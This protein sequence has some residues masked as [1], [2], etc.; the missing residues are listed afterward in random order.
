MRL[1]EVSTGT[2]PLGGAGI[3]RIAWGKADALPFPLCVS[4]TVTDENGVAT[5]VT[6]G[7]ASGNIVLVDHGLTVVGRPSRGGAAVEARALPP[8]GRPVRHRRRGPDRAAVR[9]DPP[10]LAR[11]AHDPLRR[12]GGGSRCPSLG[13]AGGVARGSRCVTASGAPWEARADLLGSTPTAPD[14]VVE[15]EADDEAHLRFGDG[16]H[17]ARPT[18]GTTF[19]A[20]YRIG[21]GT[22]G[23]VGAEAI[24]HVAERPRPGSSA[25]ATRCRRPGAS[26]P[27]RVEEVRRF[28]PVAFRTQERAVTADDYA[29]M[30]ERH[31]RVQRAAGSF[32]WTGSWRTAFVTVDPL[33]GDDDTVEEDLGTAVTRRL[34]RYRHGRRRRSRGHA[35]LRAAQD[36]DDGLR[37]AR[38]LPLRR[39]AGAPRTVQQH[40]PARRA[41]RAVPSRRVHVRPAGLPR[42]GCTRPRPRSTASRRSR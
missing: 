17:G 34:E 18:A 24:A 7:V 26:I 23:N 14:F 41:A 27:S 38:V 22:G 39:Q 2:D 19:S 35:A 6:T 4:A 3:T 37:P 20:T 28:A 13:R 21:N 25:C 33:V 9:A 42:R 36:R 30:A 1:T 29:R 11:V 10:T 31:E 12:V 32:R 8:A 15:V 5:A 40:R 16:R